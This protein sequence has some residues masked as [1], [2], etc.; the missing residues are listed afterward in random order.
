M[1]T[2]GNKVTSLT[3]RLSPLYYCHSSDIDPIANDEPAKIGHVA[4]LTVGCRGSNTDSASYYEEASDKIS[5]KPV[6]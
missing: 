3:S 1:A 2:F 6:E 4:K 5:G